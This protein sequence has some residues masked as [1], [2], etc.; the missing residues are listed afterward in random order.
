MAKLQL[1]ELSKLVYLGARQWNSPKGNLLTFVKLGDP[2][3][4]ENHEFII[5]ANKIDVNSIPLNTLV[6]P[7]F[8]MGLYNNKTSLNLV[9]LSIAK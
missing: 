3:K 7:D 2:V 1:E 6:K 5:D 8:E 9:G 4:F